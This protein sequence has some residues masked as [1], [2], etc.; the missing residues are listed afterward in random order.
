MMKEKVLLIFVNFNNFKKNT[1]GK[2]ERYKAFNENVEELKN[3][4]ISAGAG[5][6]EVLFCRQDK[7]NP[8]YFM[9]SGKLEEAKNIV[10]NKEIELVI[11]DDEITPTQQRNLQLKLDTKVLDRTALILDIFAQRAHSREGKLQVELAQLN[12]LLP[13]LTGKGIELSRLGGGIG[14]RGPGETK[15]E[16]DRRKIRKRISQLE[17]KIHQISIQ[18]DTQRKN[19]EE[20]NVFQIALVGYTNSGK[21]TLLNSTSDADGY[22]EDRLFSTLDST[23]RRL[24]IY[25]N[26]EVLISD[27]V[28]FIEKLPH[29]LIASFKSTLDEVK[30]S[31]LLLLISDISKPDFE[32]NIYSVKNVLKEIDAGQKPMVLVFNKIDKLSSIEIERLKIKH[33]EAL[34]IS[35]LKKTGFNE[36]YS[37]IKK[38]IEKHYLDIVVKI[39]YNENKLISFIYDNCQV[40]RRRNLVDCTILNLHVNSRYC[41]ILSRYIYRRRESREAN[42]V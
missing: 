15:L 3:L 30:K 8:K 7:P 14:T 42:I 26:S 25:P 16:V 6:E 11:F 36:L 10:D 17:K 29:Q 41:S 1:T 38:I 24:K 5:V 37:R 27:T 23:T 2:P 20:R 21:T 34:F 4:T 33:K 12:Y 31:D 35:A 39:P 32:N 22:V 13:R 18:R 40:L 28:G 19:R 9:G